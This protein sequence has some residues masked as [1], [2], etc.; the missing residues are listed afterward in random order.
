MRCITEIGTYNKDFYCF[1]N[2][3]STTYATD[4][5]NT[6]SITFTSIN[7][8]QRLE[9]SFETIMYILQI[10]MIPLRSQELLKATNFSL[11]NARYKL[12]RRSVRTLDRWC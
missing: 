3:P 1:F 7:V 2:T 9:G 6:G 5:V 8:D 10:T 4:S 12:C 11:L